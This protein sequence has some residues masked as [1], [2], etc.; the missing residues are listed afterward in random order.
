MKTKKKRVFE[1]P[2]HVEYRIT[3]V[4]FSRSFFFLFFPRYDNKSVRRRVFE[5][6]FW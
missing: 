3:R 4:L 5:K 1:S 6:V 2:E